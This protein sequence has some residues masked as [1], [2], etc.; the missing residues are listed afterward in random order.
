[1]YLHKENRELF[2]DA[3]LLASQKLEVPHQ[4]CIIYLEL[5]RTSADYAQGSRMRP[6]SFLLFNF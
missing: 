1:M 3:I 5:R 2:S 4:Y 6:A